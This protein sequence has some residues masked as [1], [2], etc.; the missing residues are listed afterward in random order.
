MTLSE[1]AIHMPISIQLFEKY[2]FGYYQNGEQTFKEACEK[3]GLV[4]T[5]IDE[6][7]NQLQSLSKG[8]GSLTLEDMSIDRLIDFING[9]HHSNEEAVLD[10]I[11]ASIKKLLLD[12]NLESALRTILQMANSKFADFKIKLK[13]HCEK[14][15]KI[16]FPHMRKLYELRHDKTLTELNAKKYV[17][18]NSIQLLENEHIEASA[19]LR[20]IKD[21][22]GNFSV[23]EKAPVEYKTLM[24][25][26]RE[27][28]LEFH[29]H[30]HIENNIL[31]PKVIALEEHLNIRSA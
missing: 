9:Q 4:F 30:L 10:S 26:L 3:K 6:E 24:E 15:D 14:E 29:M 21:I 11:D 5:D 12:A 7:L 16:L 19:L 27:F 22:T 2:N 31:F 18:K 1:L 17:S 28:E 13:K 20:D 25:N 8:N 23:P